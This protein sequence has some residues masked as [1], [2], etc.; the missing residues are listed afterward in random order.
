VR[1]SNRLRPW[2]T[3]LT[4]ASVVLMMGCETPINDADLPPEPE[5]EVVSEPDAVSEPDSGPEIVSEPDAEPE[6]VSAPDAGPEPDA[7]PDAG[8]ATDAASTA[9][10]SE[11]PDVVIEDAAEEDFLCESDSHCSAYWEAYSA[12]L[13]QVGGPDA[14]IDPSFYGGECESACALEDLLDYVGYYTCLLEGIPD[15]CTVE[16]VDVPDCPL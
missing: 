11:E 10:V 16:G 2:T 3:S 15:D 9:E 8:P 5:P 14:A 1:L 6:T 7:G 4:A 12:C 13:V